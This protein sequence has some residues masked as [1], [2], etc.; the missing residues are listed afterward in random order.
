[1]SDVQLGKTEAEAILFRT[2]EAWLALRA[3]L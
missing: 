1:M 2:S 3:Y